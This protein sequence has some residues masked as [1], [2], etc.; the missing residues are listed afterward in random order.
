LVPYQKI[1]SSQLPSA[2]CWTN[3]KKK[4]ES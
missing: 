3:Q 2:I 1:P 4:A